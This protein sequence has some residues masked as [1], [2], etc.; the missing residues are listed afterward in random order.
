M[1]KLLTDTALWMEMFSSPV[2]L[3]VMDHSSDLCHLNVQNADMVGSTA[4][5]VNG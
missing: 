3:A 1:Y 2:A 4:A 5:A